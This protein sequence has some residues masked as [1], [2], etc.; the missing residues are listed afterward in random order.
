M[1]DA[2]PESTKEIVFA[3]VA[4]LEALLDRRASRHHRRLHDVS[5]AERTLDVHSPVTRCEPGYIEAQCRGK[6]KF[7]RCEAIISEQSI[8]LAAMLFTWALCSWYLAS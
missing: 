1:R 6:F 7:P 3:F 4:A 5:L 8:T 2:H